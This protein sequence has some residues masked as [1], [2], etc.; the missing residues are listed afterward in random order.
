MM[1]LPVPCDDA[2][3]ETV[4]HDLF[5]IHKVE[6]INRVAWFIKGGQFTVEG[7]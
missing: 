6:S 2:N 4:G 7:A 1:L 3:T 5:D